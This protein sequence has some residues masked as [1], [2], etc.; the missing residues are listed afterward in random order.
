MIIKH[1][2]LA[3]FP[4]T[5]SVSV[6]YYCDE[7]P[8]GLTYAIDVPVIN[9]TFAT[10]DVIDE[11]VK[12]FEP[13]G[14]LERLA[15]LSTASV[16]SHLAELIPVQQQPVVENIPDAKS[17]SMAIQEALITGNVTLDGVNIPTDTI[18]S[19]PAA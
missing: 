19:F 6:N 15:E 14:Q 3:F 8:N 5:G 2:I 11:L 7:V 10:Q 13:R 12:T 17:I 4:E 1:K 18:S 9:G 16:P